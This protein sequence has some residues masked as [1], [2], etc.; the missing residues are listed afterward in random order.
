[1]AEVRGAIE[2]DPMFAGETTQVFHVG[3]PADVEAEA[4]DGVVL[5]RQQTA[6]AGVHA[7]LMLAARF[8][9]NASPPG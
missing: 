4:G 3:S 2:A 1:M 8:D 9:V 5:D 6:A 7:S